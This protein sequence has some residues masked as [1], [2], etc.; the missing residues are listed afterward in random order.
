MRFNLNKSYT[1][2]IYLYYITQKKLSQKN[3]TVI[4]LVSTH[5]QTDEIVY[6]D[7]YKIT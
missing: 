2:I 7:N 3:Y 4:S 5:I 1:Y 6:T